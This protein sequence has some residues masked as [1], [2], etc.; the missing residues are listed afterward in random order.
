MAKLILR[1]NTTTV[2]YIIEPKSIAVT[3]GKPV[4][5]SVELIIQPKP[6]YVIDATDFTHGVLHD[7]ISSMSY[8]NIGKNVL[9]KI[10]FSEQPI[11]SEITNIY[12]PISGRL[13]RVDN[14]LEITSITTRD[15]N[16]LE[17]TSSSGTT[18]STNTSSNS[19]TYKITSNGGLQQ[20]LSKTFLVPNGFY[21]EQEPTYDISG[22]NSKYKVS[23]NTFTNDNNYIIK[24]I[25]NISYNFP[26]EN[27]VSEPSNVITFR[28]TSKE[29]EVNR[30]E[31]VA[32]TEEDYKIYNV[33]Y[34]RTIGLEGG[35]KK[36][37][38]NGVPGTKFKVL[39]QDTNKNIYDFKGGGFKSETSFLTGT[40]PKSTPGVGYGTFNAFV[41]IPAST[42]ANTISTRI[43]TNAPVKTTDKEGFTTE[44]VPVV[45]NED[46]L[47]E[48]TMTLEL[49]KDSV[50]YVVHRPAL[51]SEA[52]TLTDAQITGGVENGTYAVG[53]GITNA[54]ISDWL[55]NNPITLYEGETTAYTWTI[56]VA[57]D[58][59]I[60]IN[61]QPR[62]DAS[63]TFVDWDSAYTDESAPLPKEYDNA[64]DEILTDADNISDLGG[65]ELNNV[66]ISVSPTADS[67]NISAADYVG[68]FVTVYSKVQIKLII[69]NGFFGTSD[70]N[71]ELNLNNFLTLVSI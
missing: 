47:A 68:G 51:E 7:L 11:T 25:F 18:L 30:K 52:D 42:T 70:I 48:T 21:F 27:P 23:I 67:V 66:E 13:K 28:A 55:E 57:D 35:I 38:V 17:S 2:N 5:E 64:G 8:S 59:A 69:T 40:I 54:S 62:F 63:K 61:R 20:V 1:S 60:G 14:T 4:K 3:I 36:I 12:L 46:V 6:N 24:K 41:K 29:V 71:P 22:N 33:D 39:V 53:G 31:V 58:K 65:W 43:L 9:V 19:I 16:V 56:T 15:N 50:A 37:T 32:T 34:G 45:V 49:I 26:K 44:T 10:V